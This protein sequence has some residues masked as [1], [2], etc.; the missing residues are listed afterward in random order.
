[1]D[2]EPASPGSGGIIT[3]GKPIFP[4]S[5]DI[6]SIVLEQMLI[7]RRYFLNRNLNHGYIPVLIRSTSSLP[8]VRLPCFF[9]TDGRVV[10][11]GTVGMMHS[12]LTLVQKR[13]P[14][15]EYP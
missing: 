10:H 9:L 6:F 3:G 2:A 12:T 4:P 15:P 8:E 7:F 11:L 14:V 5:G 1:M 13:F